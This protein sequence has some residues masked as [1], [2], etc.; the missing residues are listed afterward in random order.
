MKLTRLFRMALP[1]VAIASVMPLWAYDFEVDGVYYNKLTD[2]TCEVT[3]KD[4]S[5]NSY[6]GTII[7]PETVDYDGTTFTVTS[8]G[9]KAFNGCT[10]LI[11]VM[12]K[13]GTSTLSLGTNGIGKAIFYDCPLKRI[14]VGRNLSYTYNS[15]SGYSPFNKKESITSATIGGKVTALAS[16]LLYGCTGLTTVDVPNSV[17]T[18]GDYAFGMCTNLATINLGNSVS[19]IENY[20]FY[21]CQSVVKMTLPASLTYLGDCAFMSCSALAELVLADGDS[22]LEVGYNGSG[23]GAFSDCPIAS[24]YLGRDLLFNTSSLSGYSPFNKCETLTSLT[25]GE[26]VTSLGKGLFFG[27]SG[28][29]TLTIPTSVKT[30]ES[31]VFRY[32]SGLTSVDIAG[33]VMSI[34]DFAFGNCTALR[35]LRFED[36]ADVLALGNCGEGIGL[37]VGSPLETVYLGRNL[38]YNYEA[39]GGYSPFDKIATLKT[40]TIS[41]SVTE[42]ERHMFYGC[43]ALESLNIPASVASIGS[44]TFAW[45]DGIESLTIADSPNS[46]NIDKG[47]FSGSMVKSAYLGR[48]IEGE[49]EIFTDDTELYALTLGG[50]VTEVN[51]AKFDNCS[52]IRT[53]M[54]YGAVPPTLNCQFADEVYKK[55]MVYVPRT[56]LADYKAA[57]VWKNFDNLQGVDISGV[58]SVLCDTN[59]EVTVAGNNLQIS[60]NEPWRVITLGGK[61][62]MRG[63]GSASVALA[64]GLYIAIVGGHPTKVVIK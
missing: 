49:C 1:V 5:Y 18:I 54:S 2:T 28:L 58:N 19:R 35:E 50:R 26:K 51:N 7:I 31:Y 55:A 59:N 63:S 42:I 41:D 10:D 9:N 62:L 23:N 48:N 3:Y 30:I 12:I 47:V 6:L 16:G 33:S 39:D 4:S 60:G 46:I 56:V 53:I 20:A 52:A 61:E 29:T 34:G 13:D 11:D 38:S 32:C 64:K 25:I 22:E 40:L 57:N 44:F 15:N 36:S 17:V 8:V 37:F 24:L 21:G 45:C 27:C 43:S 14:Y